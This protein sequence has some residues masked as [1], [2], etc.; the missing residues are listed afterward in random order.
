MTK[1]LSGV[2]GNLAAKAGATAIFTIGLTL[3]VATAQASMVMPGIYD[4]LNHP[5]AALT[6]PGPPPV[7]Y[8]LRLD[9]FCSAS[10]TSSLCTGS[11][12]DAERTFSVEGG[13]AGVTLEWTTDLAADLSVAKISG[14][15]RRNSDDSLWTVSYD[16]TGI[17]ALSGTLGDGT[18]GWVAGESGISGTLTGTGANMGISLDLDGKANGGGQAF[19]FDNDGHRCS[20]HG[21]PCA[22]KAIAPRGWIVVDD[23]MPT[24]T[25]DWIVIAEKRPDQVSEP[26]TL[27]L[28]GLGILGLGYIRRRRLS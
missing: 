19:I 8:G 22:W 24:D 10:A 11:G 26:G 14:T 28:L 6:D 25:N 15:V 18:D 1:T 16:I 9:D 21:D 5:D 27:A 12:T 3:S 17:T 20:G 2:A 4:I 13:G 23:I 7:A